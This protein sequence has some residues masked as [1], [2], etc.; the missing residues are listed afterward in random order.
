[1]TNIQALDKMNGKTFNCEA[2]GGIVTIKGFE[3]HCEDGRLL[4]V[5]SP[6]DIRDL[7]KAFKQERS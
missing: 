2:F 4:L 1:M 3:I 5:T 7:Y 6:L